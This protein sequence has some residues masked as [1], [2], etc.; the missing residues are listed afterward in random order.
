MKKL[1]QFNDEIN[2]SAV[3]LA[4]WREKFKIFLIMLVTI[5]AIISYSVFKP[6]I[7]TNMISLEV[8]PGAKSTF[9]KFL[10]INKISHI[11]INKNNSENIRKIEINETM[12]FRNFVS[13]FLDYQE[14]ISVLKK[15]D[16]IKKNISQLSKG[17]KEKRL[18]EYASLFTLIKIKKK[19]IF[20]L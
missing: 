19:V 14:V 9:N 20:T 4:I 2:L 13:E 8:K 15:N 7:I 10:L 5:I 18:R 12:A 6:K 17:N 11:D 3:F 1:P 16:Y